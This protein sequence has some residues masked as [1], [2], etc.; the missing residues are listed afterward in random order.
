MKSRFPKI[1][2]HIQ[3]AFLTWYAE[4]QAHFP[5][6]LQYLRRKDNAI[7][8]S[9]LGLHPALGFSLT[10]WEMNVYVEWQGVFWDFLISLEAV[11]YHSVNGYFCDLC[12]VD[13]RVLFPSREAVWQDHLFDPF[14]KWLNDTLLPAKW[15]G[16]YGGV[17]QGCTWAELL[18][19]PDPK[20][21]EVLPLWLPERG[22]LSVF[23]SVD[24]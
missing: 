8:F 17:E 11:P 5:L 7:E 4:Q 13:S 19:E 6:P 23:K 15:L 2:R 21:T 12:K 16:L 14:L 22:G 1:R 18:T 10:S 20:A 9:A 24:S 3:R